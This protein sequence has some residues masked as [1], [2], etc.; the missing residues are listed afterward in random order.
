FSERYSFVWSLSASSAWIWSKAD[1]HFSFIIDHPFQFVLRD[2]SGPCQKRIHGV[3]F[4]LRSTH[5]YCF[6]YKP[7]LWFRLHCSDSRSVR[8]ARKP[9]PLYLR[10]RSRQRM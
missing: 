5:S 4:L 6:D 10:V 1:F 3:Y 2:L 7:C 8:S 9:V